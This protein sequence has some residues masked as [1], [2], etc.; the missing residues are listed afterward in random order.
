MRKFL[1]ASTILIGS[2]G[3]PAVAQPSSAFVA[4]LNDRQSWEVWFNSLSGDYQVG[5]NFWAAQRSLPHPAGCFAEGGRDLGYWSMGCV[6]AQQRLALSDIRR[7]AEPEYRLGWNAWAP[8]TVEA[9][10][11][12]ADQA[13]AERKRRPTVWRPTVKPLTGMRRTL[14]GPPTSG[15]LRPSVPGTRC[16]LTARRRWRDRRER[17]QKTRQRRSLP[18]KTRRTIV[19]RSRR[20]L[21]I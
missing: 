20:L 17:M 11:Q 14:S 1:L 6:A 19:A 9:M 21:A 4:G 15:R 12:L 3:G 8:G 7:K 16:G 10:Q 2:V 18:P 13:A 5:A